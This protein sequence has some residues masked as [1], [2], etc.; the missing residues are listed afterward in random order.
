MAPARIA[1]LSLAALLMAGPAPLPAQTAPAIAAASATDAPIRAVT[2]SAAGLAE[3]VREAGAGGGRRTISLDADIKDIDDVLKSLVVLG[4]DFDGASLRLAGPSPIEDAFASLPFTPDDLGD[5]ETLAAAMPGARVVVTSGAERIEGSIL[6]VRPPRACPEAATSP[7][8]ADL[9]L[10]DADGAITR[11]PLTGGATL[12]FSDAADLEA[13]RRGIEAVAGS[14][15]DGRRRIL[16]EAETAAGSDEPI[17]ISYVLAAPIWKSVW[18]A[19]IGADGAVAVQIWAVVEN[20]GGEDWEDVR[21]TLSSGAPRTLRAEL[22]G[23]VWAWRDVFDSAAKA[24]AAMLRSDDAAGAG[25]VAAM[26]LAPEPMAQVRAATAIEENAL[27]ARFTFEDP[28]SLKAGEMISLPFVS[29][30][31]PARQYSRVVGGSGARHP[32]LSLDITNTLAVRLPGG[33]MTL[34]ADG[35]GYRGDAGLADLAPG[36]NRIVAFAADVK[37]GIAE[38]SR[39]DENRISLRLQDGL[40]TIRKEAVTETDYRITAPADAGRTLVIDHPDDRGSVIEIVEGADGY[41]DVALEDGRQARRFE[42]DLAAGE[43]RTLR[44]RE[45]VP[46]EERVSLRDVSPELLLE[47][48]GAEISDRDRAVFEALAEARGAEADLVA[49]LA[50]TEDRIRTDIAEQ[51]RARVLL[52]SVPEG[53]EAHRRYLDTMLALEDA[54]ETGRTRAE[55]LSGLLRA[56]RSRVEE[57]VAGT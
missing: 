34:Y 52:G 28:V 7:C 18:K 26:E 27:D 8:R 20:A 40:L 31:I 9:L 5:L 56:A 24:D 49:A 41:A 33:I 45:T 42:L 14:T 57:I 17:L 51:E 54:I 32:E 4:R 48:Y 30:S 11:V 36:A 35:S 19:S 10:I 25:S 2:L 47:R 50:E 13:V 44:L 38:T 3:I 43:D 16:V 6:G 12:R 22:F 53:G 23:R 39:H 21:L 29:G 37:T 46:L 1:S 55:D 15:R